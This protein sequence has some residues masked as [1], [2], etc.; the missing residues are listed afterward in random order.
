MN[1]TTLTHIGF[2]DEPV[3]TRLAC[4]LKNDNQQADAGQTV[5]V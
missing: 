1:T 3:A 5:F 2:T 4:L